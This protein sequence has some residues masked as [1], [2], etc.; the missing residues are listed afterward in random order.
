MRLNSDATGGLRSV[1]V[2]AGLTLALALVVPGTTAK[3]Q[4]G[5][6]KTADAK[7]AESYQTI[8]LTNISQQNDAN[9]IQTALRNMLPRARVYYVPSQDALTIRANAEDMQLA[10]KMVSDLSRSRKTY[11][12]TYTIT[13]ITDG[14]R[15]GAQHF[16]L[17]VISGV[18]TTLKQGSRMPIVTGT[19][20]AGNAT[21]TSQV[22]YIDVGLNIE[23]SA[24]EYSD[25]L[26]LRTRVEQTSPEEQKSGLGPQDPVI[27]QTSLDETSMVTQ[28]KPLI[29]GSLEMPGGM[30]RQ[31]I[32]VVSEP[33]K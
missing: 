33:V 26:R 15:S 29:L 9:D 16:T 3:A 12:L 14:K 6:S 28:G 18:K 7:P 2:L 32:E 31:E 5:D 24:D 21:Q 13:D 23:A 10:Q 17:I 8:Y 22:Q 4:S 20:D 1:H 27:R 11:R 25:G 19:V 30:R